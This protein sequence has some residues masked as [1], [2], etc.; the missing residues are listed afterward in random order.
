MQ[1]AS[2]GL[3]GYT[4]TSTASLT[5]G[6]ASGSTSRVLM[7]SNAFIVSEEMTGLSSQLNM[8]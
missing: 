2:Q 6:A 4:G 5:S 3:G 1:A 8:C 7:S